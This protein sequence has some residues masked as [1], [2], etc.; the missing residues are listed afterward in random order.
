M[1]ILGQFNKGFI[2]T[3]LNNDL[4]IIDQVMRVLFEIV[5]IFACYL[6]L[7]VVCPYAYVAYTK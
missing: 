6:Y 1:E 2:I 4:F 5:I 7:S 3:R